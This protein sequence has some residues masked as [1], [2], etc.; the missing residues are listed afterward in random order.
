MEKLILKWFGGSEMNKT[1]DEK[2]SVPSERF[3]LLIK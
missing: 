2:R 3:L 1:E